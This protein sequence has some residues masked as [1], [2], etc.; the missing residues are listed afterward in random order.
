M[1]QRY[2][3]TGIGTGIGKTIVSAIV[4][5]KLKSDYWKPVQSGDLDNSDTMK[6]QSLVSNSKTVFHPETYRL[7]QPYS[8]HKSAAIDGVT[9]NLDDFVLPNTDNVLVIEGAG[10]LMVPL[11]DQ[12]LV[13]DLIKK[14]D[15]DVILVSQNYLGS[16]N[17]TIL[18][19]LALKSYGIPVKGII[20]NGEPNQNTEDY[21]LQYTALNLIGRIP[22]LKELTPEAIREA[23][24]QL[25]L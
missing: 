24:H 15:A 6:V 23:G 11:N 8:P 1:P 13:I 14:L 17:H 19:W 22:Q 20:F 4:T 5:E 12:Q 7:T 18:S 21:I 9:I 3:I 25:N 16:I 2:F 10:G